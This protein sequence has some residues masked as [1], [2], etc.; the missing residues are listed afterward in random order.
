M[1]DEQDF[2]QVTE[3]KVASERNDGMEY[4]WCVNCGHSGKFSF[5]RHNM[6]ICKECG[7]DA[8]TQLELEEILEDENL[9]RNFAAVLP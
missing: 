6:Q 4:Y 7:Y 8:L 5:R 2:P 3:P 9:K 1:I